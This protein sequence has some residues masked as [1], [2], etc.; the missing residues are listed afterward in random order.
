M[1]LMTERASDTAVLTRSERAARGRAARSSVPRSSHAEFARDADRPTPLELLAEQDRTRLRELLP[2]RY[3]RMAVSQFT[4]FRGAAL[5][6]ASDLAAT[7]RTEL[8]VQ[9]CGDAH[10]MNFGTFASPE[11]RLVFDIND[12]DETLPGPWEWDVKRLTASLE[13]AGRDNGFSGSQCRAAVVAAAAEYRR[14]MREFAGR[15]ALEV[16]YAHADI[17]LVQETYAAEL[18]PERRRKLR[19]NVSKAHARDHLSALQRFAEVADGKARIAHAPPL[20]LPLDHFARNRDD[21]AELRDQLAGML[22]AYRATLEPERRAL[23]DRYRFV[24]MARK[25]VGVGSVGTRCW[26]VLLLGNDERDPLFLQAKEAGPSVL[27]EFAGRSRYGNAGRRVVVGQRMMQTVSDV[28]LGWVRV[29][30]IDGR[31]RD[32][33]L[34]QLRDWKGSADVE[35]MNPRVLRTYGKLCA[36][37]LARAHARTGDS[38][39]IAAYLGSSDTFDTAIAEFA[40]TYADQNERDYAALREAMDAGR[41]L[42]ESGH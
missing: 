14:A 15:T 23:L 39:A 8:T 19:E 33:Y 4:Y 18:R 32:F 20:I 37:T 38:I 1:T 21:A 29:T 7:P 3:E 42:A 22:A 24:D 30:G 10:L 13:I 27:E 40:A 12:F 6:M 35:T 5:P 41:V 28:F 25:V 36:W 2:I 17:N 31:S 34:R 16:W 11:R 9:V 26:M